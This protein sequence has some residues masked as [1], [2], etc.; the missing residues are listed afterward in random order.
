M[1]IIAVAGRLFA[2]SNRGY[3]EAVRIR[4]GK[5]ATEIPRVP[6]G[7]EKP[8]SERSR[9]VELGYAV[10]WRISEYLRH[11]RFRPGL[12]HRLRPMALLGGF[13]NPG[14]YEDGYYLFTVDFNSMKATALFEADYNVMYSLLS[15][16]VFLTSTGEY[17]L[18]DEGST[19]AI[20]WVRFDDSYLEPGQG[21]YE[22]TPQAYEPDFGGLTCSS[23]A[24]RATRRGTSKPLV[25]LELW[26]LKS[27]IRPRMYTGECRSCQTWLRRSA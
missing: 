13:S 8:R 22:G 19:T 18:A 6:V 11:P 4:T 26:G 5:T 27:V 17:V 25:A 1:A 23:P 15:Y 24:W 12:S 16:D 3:T 2:D 14:T 21:S 9:P 20:F 10:D 7:I